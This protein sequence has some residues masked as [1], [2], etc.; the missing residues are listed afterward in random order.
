[1]KFRDWKEWE[2]GELSVDVIKFLVI[3]FI[4]Y[5]YKNDVVFVC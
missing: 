1:M 4:I 5:Y 2:D 3:L